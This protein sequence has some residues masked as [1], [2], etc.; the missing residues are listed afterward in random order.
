MPHSAGLHETVD[1]VLS[2]NWTSA[3]QSVRGLVRHFGTAW[4]K[5]GLELLELDIS[6]PG[7]NDRLRDIL[8]SRRVR[9]V[10]ATSGIGA[11]IMIDGQNLW[12]KLNLPLFSLL[13]DHPAYMAANHRTQPKTVVL[14]Y[15]F[16]D[17]ALYQASDVRAD[18]I[19]T[20]IDY[21]VPDLAPR[22]TSAQRRPRIIFA[23]TGNSPAVLAQSWRDAPKFERILYDVLDEL[24]PARRSNV[25]ASE[26]PP[27]IARVAAA[28]RLELQP[29]DLLSR[30]L[31][32]QVDDY[33][34][35]EKS[36]SIAR[37]ILPFEVD[38]FGAA[39]EHID[40]SGARARFHGPVAYERLEADFSSATASITMNP[41]IDLS[42]HDRF[43][44]ALGAGIVPISDRNAYTELNFPDI[45]PYTFDFSPG[46]IAAAVERV[47]ASPEVALEAARAAR[48]RPGMGVDVAAA[49]ILAIMD[50]AAFLHGAPKA[51][52]NFFVA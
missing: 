12:A 19:V 47:T 48:A 51:A 5:A 18:N 31:I 27:A 8:N 52:Q 14:G 26:F 39:W 35:R 49:E 37:A 6:A 50:S 21:G 23:K 20:S 41:N 11:N 10:L 9:F 28:H 7:W 42:V 34:R 25:F 33:V 24:A 46:S 1:V 43:F 3:Y 17:H 22:E 32:A 44:T 38:V 4:G 15:M 40:T 2:L 16:R 45:L 36:T 30:F 29:F 13:L